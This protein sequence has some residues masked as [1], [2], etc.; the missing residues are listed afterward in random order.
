MSTLKST[1]YVMSDALKILY[2]LILDVVIVALVTILVVWRI[3]PAHPLA[4]L[5]VCILFLGNILIVRRSFRG[6]TARNKDGVPGLLWFAAAVFTVGALVAIVFW[7]RSPSLMLA[8]QTIIA[9]LL[10]GYVW[11]LVYRVR[12]KT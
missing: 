12:R 8:G 3:L 4:L 7:S 10:A 2:L 5:T 11:F 1:E 6:Q 9:V